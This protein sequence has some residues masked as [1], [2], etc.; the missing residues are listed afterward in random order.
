MS[1]DPVVKLKKHVEHIRSK[2]CVYTVDVGGTRNPE[3]HSIVIENA[4]RTYVDNPRVR[5]NGKSDWFDA[6]TMIA[7]TVRGFRTDAEKAIAL[8]YLF[9]G[10]RFQRSNVDRHSCNAVALLGSYGYGICGHSAAA[11]SALAKKAGLKSRYWE[12][13]H[14]TVT[15]V[16]FDGA[17]HMLDANVPVFYL[18]RDNW[19]IASIA[20]L[21]EDPDLVGRTSL[22]AGRNL[23]AHQPWFATKEYHRAYPTQSAPAM[24]DRSLGYS[25]KPFERFERF[26]KP[27]SFKY[28]DQANTP[29]AP[30]R[31]ANGRFIYE[32]DLA[33]ASPLDWLRNA[34]AF[35]RNLV[36][37]KGASPALRVDKGQVPVY[38]LASNIAYD[39][40]SGYVMAGG[41]LALSGRKSGDSE[42]DELTVRVVPYGT[43][44]EG[45]LLFQAMG[46]GEIVT[47]VDLAPG[48]QPWGNEGCYFYEVIVGMQ[49]N[50]TTGNTTGLDAL[51]LETDVQ[52]APEALPALRVG[53]NE[54][55]YSD[56]SAGARDVRI[57]HVW[58]ER[59]GGEPP[60]APTG[61]A[62]AGKEKVDTFA[63]VLEWRQPEGTDEIADYQILV[64]RYPHCRLPHCANLYGSTGQ[65]T[66]HFTVTGGWLI[67]GKTWFW[68]VR[69][70]DKSGDFGPWSQIASFRT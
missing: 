6:K 38:D 19:T 33:K 22:C 67:P 9:E 58:R 43:G 24:A 53:D 3:N 10:T 31:Y 32:P 52:V 7:D 30:K 46:T 56:E 20:D 65:A 35:A 28:H 69:A 8:L 50:G 2:K 55:A 40:R 17:W 49:A 25:L 4:G 12:I 5:A 23:A 39:V 36:W 66:T 70:K 45:K 26:W 41:R 21:E 15:E 62:P 14:H 1:K 48:I 42:R 57:T 13:N 59:S 27:V 54:I 11:Q 44:R 63:P 51:R 60:Q 16:F 29:A 37:A 47:E 64:S 18:K 68:K 34:H 61:L